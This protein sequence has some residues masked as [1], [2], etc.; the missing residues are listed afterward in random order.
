[1]I[2]YNE[3]FNKL[4]EHPDQ[5]WAKSFLIEG[6]SVRPDDIIK[7]FIDFTMPDIAVEIGTHRGLSTAVIASGCPEVYTF[8]I[9]PHRGNRGDTWKL[10]EYLKV[11]L[12]IMEI[13]C[14]SE[15]Q[16][17]AMAETIIDA[18]NHTAAF[19]DGAH[20]PEAVKADYNACR[21]SDWIL[22]D[23]IDGIGSARDELGIIPITK[24]FG[25]ISK[26]E[27]R[28][29]PEI[30]KCNWA[31]PIIDGRADKKAWGKFIYENWPDI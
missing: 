16:I 2:G 14:K 15:H 13:T 26:E 29:P 17:R 10:W 12:N 18:K 28:I 19:I 4:K 1:M 30:F 6:T 24:R 5:E 25:Y 11:D 27:K 9:S 3:I 23:D 20:T 21:Y 7:K 31:E 22:F 8:E